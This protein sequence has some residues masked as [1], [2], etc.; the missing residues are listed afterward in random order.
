VGDSVS[1]TGS[2]SNHIPIL[3]Q[4]ID[5]HTESG[6]TY[7]YS[8]YITVGEGSGF[9]HAITEE[10]LLAMFTL[11]DV[12]NVES[13]VFVKKRKLTTPSINGRGYGCR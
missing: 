2:F 1:D 9:I 3:V 4:V 8:D 12:L 5:D 13:A 10:T 6:S 7:A 11:S